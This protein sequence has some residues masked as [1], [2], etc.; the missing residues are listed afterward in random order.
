[1]AA[2]FGQSSQTLWG[3]DLRLPAL[4]AGE[5]E[6]RRKNFWSFAKAEAGFGR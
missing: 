2:R 1:M 6:T 4:P 3:F 5:A